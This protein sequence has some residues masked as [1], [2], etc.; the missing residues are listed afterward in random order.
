VVRS[1]V[2]R[3]ASPEERQAAHRVLADAI[4][5]DVDPR[6]PRLHGPKELLWIDGASHVDLYD[7]P[8][9]VNPAAE[10]LT[11]FFSN[12]LTPSA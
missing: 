7:T 8:E 9:Y 2:Y 12:E 10:K 1:A 4:D 3:A 5:P 11:G 6:S